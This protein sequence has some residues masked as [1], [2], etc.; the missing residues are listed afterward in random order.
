MAR[1]IG[2]RKGRRQGR[3]ERGGKEEGRKETENGNTNLSIIH[4]QYYLPLSA[5]KT[6]QKGMCHIVLVVTATY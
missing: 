5:Q 4:D 6:K 2:K 3:R 1:K